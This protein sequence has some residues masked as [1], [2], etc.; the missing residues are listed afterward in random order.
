MPLERP[1]Y[2]PLPQADDS[3]SYPPTLFYH[4]ASLPPS[5]QLIANLDHLLQLFISLHAIRVDDNPSTYFLSFKPYWSVAVDSQVALQSASGRFNL[6]VQVSHD[7]SRPFQLV[8]P[9]INKG[10]KV[11]KSAFKQ[12][13]PQYYE[14]GPVS[15]EGK[16]EIEKQQPPQA[17]A[18]KTSAVKTFSPV[19]TIMSKKLAPPAVFGPKRGCATPHSGA[20]AIA[21]TSNHA[22]VNIDSS[23][24]IEFIDQVSMLKMARR[25]RKIAPK[26]VR[27]DSD[28]QKIDPAHAAPLNPHVMS[29]NR[30]LDVIMQE[31]FD[32]G[33]R[34]VS[35]PARP[36]TARNL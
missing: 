1:L 28:L 29:D 11:G 10:S 31:Q 9:K 13:R 25:K 23:F 26:Q 6:A 24:F 30:P 27:S 36:N 33:E 3:G 21:T 5:Q 7:Y 4:N 2:P 34:L 32:N 16:T 19:L 35:K 8:K 22:L 12:S 14:L 15:D 20:L 17:S 18:G